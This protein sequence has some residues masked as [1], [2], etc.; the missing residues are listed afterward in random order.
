M[1]KSDITYVTG[2]VFAALVSALYCIIMKFNITVPRYFPTEHKWMMHKVDGLP[3]QGWYGMQAYA[4]IAAGIVTFV[5][6]MILKSKATD[7]PLRP[8]A[9]KRIGISVSV[10]VVVCLTFIM[11]H[12]FKHCGIL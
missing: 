4:F 6:Y 12:H 1:K 10:I 3:S 2:S 8:A 7:T 5:I 11:H 9:A